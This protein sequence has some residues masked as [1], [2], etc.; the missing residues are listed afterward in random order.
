M[1]LEA[2]FVLESINVVVYVFYYR[3][4]DCIVIIRCYDEDHEQSVNKRS[5]HLG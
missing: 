3:L 1:R 5:A 4:G 2:I